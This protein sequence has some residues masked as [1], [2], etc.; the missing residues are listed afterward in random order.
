MNKT[1]LNWLSNCGLPAMTHEWI[2]WCITFAGV[3]LI[4]YL[5]NF[6]CSRLLIPGIR[7]LTRKTNFV[8]DDIMLND[9]MLKD[10]S[11]L[12]PP[13]L[14]AVLLPMLFVEGSESLDFMLRVNY[15]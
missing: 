3:F 14:L 1:I 13:I 10:I 12:V 6:I 7:R 8:W 5:V 11:R 15:I 2:Y 4:V 9:A